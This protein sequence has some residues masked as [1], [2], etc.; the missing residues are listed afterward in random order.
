MIQP[1]PLPFAKRLHDPSELGALKNQPV[2]A[3]IKA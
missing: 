3:F 1:I 2:D